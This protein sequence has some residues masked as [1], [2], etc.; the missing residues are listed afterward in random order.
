MATN[1]EKKICLDVAAD[2]CSADSLSFAG[3][4]CT[5]DQH[6]KPQTGHVLPLP[7]AK[8]DP[9]FA[10]SHSST[11]PPSSPIG[12]P[13]KISIADLLFSKDSLP[14][15]PRSSNNSRKSSGNELGIN[16]AAKNPNTLVKKQANNRSFGLKIFKSFGTP[17]RSCSALEP[18][19]SMKV[20]ALRQQ[21]EKLH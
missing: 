14:P 12:S 13:S 17:C 1:M 9:E 11:P 20:Q 7:P 18:S 21:N 16:K 8:H 5:Q 6:S 10:F 2:I 3:L 15:I 19:R 4:I